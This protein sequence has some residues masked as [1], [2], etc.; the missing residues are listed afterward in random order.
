[1]FNRE[2]A[3]ADRSYD[4]AA[5]RV[6]KGRVSAQKVSLSAIVGGRPAL[7]V[8]HITRLGRDQAPEWPNGHGYRCEIEGEPSFTFIGELGIHGEDEHDQG[9]IGTAMH[10]VHAIRH[11]CAASP[12]IKTVLD[13]PMIIGRGTIAP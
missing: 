13:M 8:E 5:G 12:G 10:G 7:T 9:C 11:V 6:E 3:V 1:V 2:V 4:V